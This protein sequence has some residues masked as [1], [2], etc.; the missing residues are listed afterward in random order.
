MAALRRGGV[1]SSCLPPYVEL[2]SGIA[3]SCS[4]FWKLFRN[5]GYLLV[6][7]LLM[8][9]GSSVSSASQKGLQ[10][11]R[12]LIGREGMWYGDAVLGEKLDCKGE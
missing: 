12:F 8:G 2:D 1:N 3:S 4:S 11:Q 10:L 5:L 7:V 6:T 9:G